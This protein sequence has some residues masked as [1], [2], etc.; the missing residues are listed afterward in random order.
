MARFAAISVC[1]RVLVLHTMARHTRTRQVLVSLS[2]VTLGAGNITVCAYQGKPRL[3]VI[4]RLDLTPTLLRV[5]TFA[6]NAKPSLVWIV[7]FVAVDAAPGRFTELL[8][9]RMAAVAAGP[10]VCSHE[11]EIRE[12]VIK[13]FAIELR[14]VEFPPF[15]F[16]VAGFAFGARC[17]VLTAM[18][19]AR[20]LPVGR[21]GLVAREAQAGLGLACKGL[22]ASVAVL[23]QLRVTAAEGSR[24]DQLFK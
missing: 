13:G 9:A 18:K 6:S 15:V 16:T 4:E 20:R 17:L 19:P 2:Y 10:F 23:L 5:T 21:N 8:G 14:D 12:R 7:A 11:H 24:H 3:A 1:P 22:M